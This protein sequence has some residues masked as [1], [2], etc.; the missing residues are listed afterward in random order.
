MPSPPPRPR[1][2]RRGRRPRNSVFSSGVPVGRPGG[3]RLT[4]SLRPLP[5]PPPAPPQASLLEYAKG[6][7][8]AQAGSP[9]VDA[10]IAL[11]AFWGQAQRRA[12]LAA[13]GLAGLNVLALINAH[14]AAALS[15]GIERDFAGK[16]QHVVFYDAGATATQARA[17][18]WG[19]VGV[20]F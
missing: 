2:S 17:L 11:P 12:L 9:V 18:L 8:D 1:R 20:G 16:V 4:P 14:S 7:T 3:E 13:A 15:Y 5:R 6:I 10:V 19:A